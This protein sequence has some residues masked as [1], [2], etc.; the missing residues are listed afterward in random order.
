M[1]SAKSNTPN[2]ACHSEMALGVF[3]VSA[4]AH[5]YAWVAGLGRGQGLTDLQPVVTTG[6]TATAWSALLYIVLW[7]FPG[8][9]GRTVLGG[10]LKAE[11]FCGIWVG[12]APIGFSLSAL[13]PAPLYA[14]P[15]MVYVAILINV[16]GIAMGPGLG[17]VVLRSMRA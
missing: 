10:A 3:A 16:S 8:L 13:L 9:L 14:G 4:A 15:A 5:L 2:A 11:L 6:I 12:A 1:Q 7:R 17:W